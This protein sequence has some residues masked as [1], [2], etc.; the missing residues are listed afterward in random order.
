M[1]VNINNDVSI[2]THARRSYVNVTLLLPTA[3]RG[4]EDDSSIYLSRK[5]E[6]NRWEFV[7]EGLAQL[8]SPRTPPAERKAQQGIRIAKNI[9]NKEAISA[10]APTWRRRQRRPGALK[11][12]KGNEELLVKPEVM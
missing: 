11:V 8:P 6:K 4:A 9:D 1:Y 5:K 12:E 3:G 2:R 7:F 10:C